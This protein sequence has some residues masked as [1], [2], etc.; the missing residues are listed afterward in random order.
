MYHPEDSQYPVY[1]HFVL[2]K[3]YISSEIKYTYDNV[4]PCKV[5][6]SVVFGIFTEL[7]NNQYHLSLE[8]FKPFFLN[9]FEQRLPRDV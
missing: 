9:E 6:H 1:V 5:C 7:D 2:L 4:H 8:Y 3:K